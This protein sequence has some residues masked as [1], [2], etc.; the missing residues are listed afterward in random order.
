MLLQKCRFR[1]IPK[2]DNLVFKELTLLLSK[3]SFR[4]ASQKWITHE[5]LKGDFRN[6]NMS[7]IW[8]FTRKLG[9]RS[10]NKKQNILLISNH[11]YEHRGKKE[12]KQT[13]FL[14]R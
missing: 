4:T 5:C 9:W 1:I 11:L 6:Q 13:F 7:V 12:N 14:L 8:L 10:E 2:S 3:K